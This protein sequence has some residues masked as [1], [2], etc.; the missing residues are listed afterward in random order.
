MAETASF[1]GTPDLELGPCNIYVKQPITLDWDDESGWTDLGL[2]ENILWRRIASK[3]DLVAA[4]R[5]TRP[6]DKV[7]TAQQVQIEANLGQAFLERLELVVQDSVLWL[8]IASE[9]R[10]S[11]DADLAFICPASRL[12]RD[13]LDESLPVSRWVGVIVLRRETTRFPIRSKPPIR[14]LL[15]V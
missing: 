8:E 3:T 9:L 1:L 13:L 12:P 14:D 6:A 7:I 2:V 4:Q 10:I 5:G 11:N 15:L